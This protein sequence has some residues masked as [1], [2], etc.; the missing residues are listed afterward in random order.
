MT[1]HR[2]LLTE[3]FTELVWI[4]FWSLEC[5][6]T[7]VGMGEQLTAE[8]VPINAMGGQRGTSAGW[9]RTSAFRLI[10][11]KSALRCNGTVGT[12]QNIAAASP[13]TWSGVRAQPPGGVFARKKKKSTALSKHTD[14]VSSTNQ[15][16]AFSQ[17]FFNPSLTPHERKSFR[18][19]KN[20]VPNFKKLKKI[21][22]KFC[23]ENIKNVRTERRRFHKV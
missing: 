22:K 19:G 8:A 13:P 3:D 7:M 11:S 18:K 15:E 5:F 12:D 10:S 1:M 6:Q 21:K 14:L 2:F 23:T 16:K 20:P 17:S 4:F 9:G